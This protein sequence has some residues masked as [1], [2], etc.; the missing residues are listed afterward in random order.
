MNQILNKFLSLFCCRCLSYIDLWEAS[1]GS[2]SD[3]S[4]V[5]EPSPRFEWKVVEKTGETINQSLGRDKVNMDDLFDEVVIV[6]NIYSTLEEPKPS[7]EEMWTQIFQHC[8]KEKISVPNLELVLE[9]VYSLPGTSA[10]VERVFSLMNNVWRDDRCSLKETTVKS[11]IFSKMN[12][13]LNCLVFHEKIKTQKNFL[14]K[15]LSQHKYP[16]WSGG[17]GTETE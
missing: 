3:F 10:P 17:D 9:Y 11:I 16:Q 13:N 7:G 1:F 6:K 8:K 2:A 12:I 4:W 14:L 15:V 5:N